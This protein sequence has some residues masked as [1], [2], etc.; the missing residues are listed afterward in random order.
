VNATEKH[1]FCVEW[2]VV[3]LKGMS[4]TYAFNQVAFSLEALMD[5]LKVHG[6]S[7]DLRELVLVF[8]D[9]T[10]Y[11]SV[12]LEAPLTNFKLGL[13][14]ESDA[15]RRTGWRKTIVNHRPLEMETLLDL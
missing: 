1:A 4:L 10:C 5:L 13:F 15:I 14:L 9:A 8:V 7:K 6:L 2:I 11:L 3:F 12:N